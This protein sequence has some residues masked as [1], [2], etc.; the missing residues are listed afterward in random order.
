MSQDEVR[1]FCKYF[2]YK[3][4]NNPTKQALESFLKIK[5][6]TQQEEMTTWAPLEHFKW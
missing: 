5:K 4:Q 3:P 1:W 6:H 2:A